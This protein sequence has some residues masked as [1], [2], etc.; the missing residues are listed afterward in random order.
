MK[1]IR[2][3]PILYLFIFCLI[4]EVYADSIKIGV[5]APLTGEWARTGEMAVKGAKLAAEEINAKTDNKIE[6]LIEDSSEATSGAK[7]VSAYQS[8]R[9]RGVRFFVG[10]VGAMAALALAPILKKDPEAIIIT[11][12]VGIKDFHETSENIFNIRGVDEIG[13]RFVAQFAYAKGFK[14]ISIFS[15]QQAWEK[16]QGDAFEDEF[17]KIGGQILKKVETDPSSTDISVESTQIVKSNPQAIFFSNYTQL[18]LAARKVHEHGFQ[19][20]FFA[21]QVDASH[22]SIAERDLQHTYFAAFPEADEGFKSRFLK[23]YSAE[24]SYPSDT[25]YDAIVALDKAIFANASKDSSAICKILAAEKFLGASGE[26][27]FNNSRL[28]KRSYVIKQVQGKDLV[29]EKEG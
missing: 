15:S 6:L 7:A 28:A 19:G 1:F 27:N 11:P 9:S 5:L 14:R 4:S 12:S 20:Q 8:L 29:P 24:A 3:I 16:T 21:A 2:T 10:P 18:P 26:V 25:A 23:S 22:L 17:K 13:T